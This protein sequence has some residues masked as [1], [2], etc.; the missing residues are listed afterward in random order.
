MIPMRSRNDLGRFLN[1]RGLLGSGVEVGAARGDF[2]RVILDSWQGKK[3]YLVD[4]WTPQ[5]KFDYQDIHNVDQARHEQ[6][7]LHLQSQLK[8]H[9]RRYEIVRAFSRDAA[10]RFADASLDFVYLDA[11]HKYPFIAEDLRLWW[12]KVKPGGW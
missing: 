3:L 4:C 9:E 10:A 11:N 6:N 7:L 5:D 12:P 8:P 2:S 1:R